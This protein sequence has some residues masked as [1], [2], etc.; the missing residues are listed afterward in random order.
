LLV[1]SKSIDDDLRG[2]LLDTGVVVW[3][4]AAKGAMRRLAV[5]TGATDVARLEDA[6]AADVGQARFVRRPRRGWLV[7]GE[8][9]TATFVVPAHAKPS[10]DAAI[11]SGERLLRAAGAVLA[12]AS[13]V[14]GG[15]RWQRGVATSLRKAADLAPG[16]APLAIR[17]AA[18][19]FDGLTDDLLRNGGRDALAGGTLPDAMGIVDPA[20]CVRLAVDGAFE[21][22][23]AIL[24]LD[25]AY[26]KRPSSAVGLRG[27]AGRS[28]SRKGMPGDIPPLM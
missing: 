12:D 8:G 2:L 17:A 18:D 1:C 7:Q 19:V 27:S 16:K 13:V 28:G 23:L 3:T 25:A 5:A 9:P 11:E 24:R 15:G 20:R 22:A 10:A 21:T 6:V 4:D 14:P 26:A